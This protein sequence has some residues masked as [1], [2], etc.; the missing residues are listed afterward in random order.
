M[1]KKKYNFI[2]LAIVICII[3]TSCSNI[4]EGIIIDKQFIPEHIE[5]SIILSPRKIGKITVSY[6]IPIRRHYSDQWLII[7]ENINEQ[8]EKITK[9]FNVTE[10]TYNA[11]NIGDYFHFNCYRDHVGAIYTEEKG[12]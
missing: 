6:P 9:T 3:F 5:H 8:N 2:I 7:V 12:E 1:Q 4:T 11:Y 10:N